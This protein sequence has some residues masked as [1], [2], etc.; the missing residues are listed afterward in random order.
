M[1]LQLMGTIDYKSLIEN[2]TSDKQRVIYELV[3]TLDKNE[4]KRLIKS[5]AKE[6]GYSL[7]EEQ[8]EL[9]D[10]VFDASEYVS[11]EFPSRPVKNIDS[12]LNHVKEDFLSAEPVKYEK[13]LRKERTSHPNNKPREY[14]LGMYENDSGYAVCQ[15]CKRPFPQKYIEV[16]EA[17]NLGIE[18]HQLY[19][20]LCKNCGVDY[21]TLRGNKKNRKYI[22]YFQKAI[23][24]VDTTEE[25]DEYNLKASDEIVVHFTQTHI[26]EIKEILSLIRT[27]G[28]KPLDSKR[29]DQKNDQ[30]NLS[31]LDI[32]YEESDDEDVVSEHCKTSFRETSSGVEFTVDI[33][34]DNDIH[35]KILGKKVGEIVDVAQGVRFE[36]VSIE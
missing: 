7:S 16:S 32:I 22:A 36:I 25:L 29:F 33:D 31:M 14:V 18:M 10:S 21:K 24:D 34:P 23:Y 6:L 28:I 2:E 17:V 3:S 27:M 5:L 19:L 13:V 4:K 26:T 1:G 12:L 11:D 35:K 15:I 8:T 30:Q 20:C 9:S